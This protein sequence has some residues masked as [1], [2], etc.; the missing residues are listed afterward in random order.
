VFV[1]VTRLDRTKVRVTSDNARIGTF[2]VDLNRIGV[3]LFNVGG[4]S[5]FIAYTS[6]NPP[7]V[8]L[9]ARGE[10]SYGG[11]KREKKPARREPR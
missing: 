9:T 3:N 5:T 10:V 4:D 1:T 6:K 8:V 2:D 7:E 11:I